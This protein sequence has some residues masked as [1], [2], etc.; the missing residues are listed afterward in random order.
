MSKFKFDA[1]QRVIS[2]IVLTLSLWIMNQLVD[3]PWLIY[4]VLASGLATMIT[5]IATLIYE[6]LIHKH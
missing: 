5:L 4:L 2:L 3:W 1:T 6:L